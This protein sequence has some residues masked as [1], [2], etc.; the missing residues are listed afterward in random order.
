MRRKDREVTDKT[1]LEKIIAQCKTACVSMIDDELKMPYVV[2][3]SY[4]FELN[5]QVEQNNKSVNKLTLYFHCAKEGRKME[6]L[7]KNNKV[8]FTIFCEG[9][10]VFPEEPCNSIYYFSSI[11]GNGIVEFIDNIEKKVLLFLK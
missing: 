9:V 5:T 2:P 8:C 4:G 10:G 3:L 7:Q 1:E 11:I 6:L